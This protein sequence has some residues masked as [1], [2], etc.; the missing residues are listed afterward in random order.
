MSQ[1]EYLAIF[2][3]IG[4]YRRTSGPKRRLVPTTN[5]NL[6]DKGGL[7]S[8]DANPSRSR[9]RADE[10]GDMSLTSKQAAIHNLEEKDLGFLELEIPVGAQVLSRTQKTAI[11][12]HHDL[13]CSEDKENS[14]ISV[15]LYGIVED[16]RVPVLQE[17][18]KI[19]DLRQLK[20]IIKAG[21]FRCI[22][23]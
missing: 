3:G 18:R 14:P 20:T 23:V 9:R 19:C 5:T 6:I 13:D 2:D 12:L 15:A 10:E 8:A 11:S 7:I 21:C 16:E 4:L 17:L 22:N 1:D